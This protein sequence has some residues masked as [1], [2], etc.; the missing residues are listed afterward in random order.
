MMTGLGRALCGKRTPGKLSQQDN[1]MMDL[2]NQR[3]APSGHLGGGL[4]PAEGGQ[5]L[6]REVASPPHNS[7]DVGQECV[8]EEIVADE[9][10]T[11]RYSDRTLLSLTEELNKL[12]CRKKALDKQ[13]NLIARQVE[14][15]ILSHQV[16]TEAMGLGDSRYIRLAVNETAHS[17]IVMGLSWAG[18]STLIFLIFF[19]LILTLFVALQPCRSSS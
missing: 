5:S 2:A 1:K 17:D 15:Q 8:S 14:L 12:K 6:T 10:S 3:L 9:H 13:S 4:P 18:T 11:L 19:N 7:G 16:T